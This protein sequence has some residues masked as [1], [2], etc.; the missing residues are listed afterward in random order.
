MHL[1]GPEASVPLASFRLAAGLLACIRSL[2]SGIAQTQNRHGN[3]GRFQDMPV[4]PDHLA[5]THYTI[6]ETI[7]GSQTTGGLTCRRT[8]CWQGRTCY[9]KPQ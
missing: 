1:F 5:V 2:L 8:V 3:L 4:T 6:E 7:A 9:S